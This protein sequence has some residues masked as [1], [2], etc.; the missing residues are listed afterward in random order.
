MT[1]RERREARAARLNEWADKRSDKATAAFEQSHAMADLIPFGQPILAGHHSQGRDQ[2]YRA[3]IA[4]KM[5]QAVEHA[6]KAKSMR[7]KAANIA[8]ATDGSIFS[9]DPD[10]IEALK[11]R[12][13]ALEAE[14]ARLTAYN[15][16]CRRGTPDPGLLDEYQRGGLVSCA[17]VGQLRSNGAMPAYAGSN[18]SGRISAARKRLAELEAKS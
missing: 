17:K 18:L 6:D 16:S 7:S 5:D 4:G 9:D 1:T 11:A 12:I 10:A 2:N 15:A 8:A 14:R 13:S 3:R